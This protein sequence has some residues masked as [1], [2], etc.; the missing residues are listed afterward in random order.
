MVHPKPASPAR[1]ALYGYLLGREVDRAL[2]PRIVQAYEAFKADPT[3]AAPDVPFQ[4]L[5]SLPLDKERW[6]EIARN[7]SWQMLR[8]N[9]STLARHGAFAVPGVA[10]AVAAKLRDPAAIRK[11]KAFP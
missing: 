3:G 11:A 5:T 4:M 10:A 9:L 6:A 2:L 8:M 1:A 7:G